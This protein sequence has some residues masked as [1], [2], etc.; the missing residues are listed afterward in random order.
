MKIKLDMTSENSNFNVEEMLKEGKREF[1]R[2][3]VGMIG[4]IVITAVGFY[5]NTQAELSSH[6]S[7]IN[8]MQRQIENKADQAAIE[9]RLDRMENKL[10]NLIQLQLNRNE[11]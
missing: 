9:K 4:L 10:D 1:V 11:P 5:F 6:Q 7:E 2:W 3:I 8:R